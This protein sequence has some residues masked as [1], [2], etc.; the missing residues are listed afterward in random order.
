MMKRPLMLSVFLATALSLSTGFVLA[1]D[2]APAQEK[3]Q[4]KKQVQVYGG[5]LMTK[6]ER[7]EYRAKM[8]AAKKLLK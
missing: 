8:R 5:Q 3:T 1:A 4:T 6:Q 2:Q 7:N